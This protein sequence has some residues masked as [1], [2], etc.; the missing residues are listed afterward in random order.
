M[1]QAVEEATPLRVLYLEASLSE[2]ERVR[3]SLAS[4]DIVRQVIRT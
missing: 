1:D 2:A 3:G 4:K